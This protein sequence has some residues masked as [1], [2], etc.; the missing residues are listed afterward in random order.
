MFRL[1][2]HDKG[3]GKGPE[4]VVVYNPLREAEDALKG[5]NMGETLRAALK[6]SSVSG[7]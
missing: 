4:G 3:G 2:K 7:L 5:S 1:G 6:V